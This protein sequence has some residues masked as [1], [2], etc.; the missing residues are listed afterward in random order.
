M[1]AQN[2]PSDPAS[3]PKR[4]ARSEEARWVESIGQSRWIG[5]ELVTGCGGGVCFLILLGIAVYFRS[6]ALFALLPIPVVLGLLGAWHGKRQ[7]YR[8]IVCPFCGFNPTRRKSDGRPRRDYY[9][10]LAELRRLD[11]CPNCGGVG[12]RATD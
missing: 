5:F 11:A 6:G 7:F 12:A 1:A 3:K 4:T 9:K 2:P 8:R 10:V